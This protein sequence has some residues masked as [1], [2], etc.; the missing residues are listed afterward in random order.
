[1]GIFD[2][3]FGKKPDN[4]NQVKKNNSEIEESSEMKKKPV[5]NLNKVENVIIENK[6]TENS[7]SSRPDWFTGVWLEEGG[8]ELS[9]KLEKCY[10]SAEERSIYLYI[11]NSLLFDKDGVFKFKDNFGETVIEN[12][13]YRN[14]DEVLKKAI[15]WFKKNNSDAYSIL[16]KDII[17]KIY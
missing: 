7:E 17:D 3:L 10:L 16:L 14:N 2:K 4:S 12:E 9:F 1:M 15:E 8:Q 5:N 11:K 6:K 13:L